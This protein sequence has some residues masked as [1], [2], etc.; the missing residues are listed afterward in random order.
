MR[1]SQCTCWS[2][3]FC[4]ERCRP[5]LSQSSFEILLEIPVD[6][7]VG[8]AVGDVL[9]QAGAAPIVEETAKGLALLAFLVFAYKEFDDA[10]DGIV[11]GAMIGFGFAFTENILYV[12][13]SIAQDGIGAGAVLI[14]LRTVVFG[15][16]HAFFTSLMGACIGAARLTPRLAHRLALLVAGFL[17]AASFH[18]IHN[19]GAALVDSA[20]VVA[21]LISVVFDWGGI[22]CLLL[23]VV[24]SWRK[25]QGWM[26]EELA[27]EVR[28]GVLT[29]E[30]YAAIASPAGRQ[31][32]L[33]KVLR[34]EGWVS[35]R[36]MQRLYTLQTELAFKKHQRRIM[37]EEHGL[38][39]AI[40]HLRDDIVQ[41]RMAVGAI[42]A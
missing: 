32:L 10:L 18:A 6:A 27:D 26:K 16:N 37:G 14:F 22:L 2:W 17:L 41:E 19:L 8:T 1:K 29:L 25:E 11:Y 36:R 35:Y 31:R 20:G 4:G 3:R 30:E 9:V 23:V 34:R 42:P 15:L 13:S 28:L 40:D 7:L 39:A 33:G 5:S 24:A 38:T 12:A 21:L